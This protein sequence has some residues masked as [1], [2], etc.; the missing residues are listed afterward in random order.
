MASLDAVAFTLSLVSLVAS[1]FGAFIGVVYHLEMRRNLM[2]L[3]EV[4]LS[5]KKKR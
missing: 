5:M 2:N 4:V 3:R 1:L